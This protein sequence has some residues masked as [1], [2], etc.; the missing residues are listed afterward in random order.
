MRQYTEFT[1]KYLVALVTSLTTI[2]MSVA[3]E[4]HDGT[5][6]SAFGTVTIDGV[7][8][9]GEWDG[10]ACVAFNFVTFGDTHPTTF[11][12]K[13]DEIY[14]Y[15]LAV[16]QNEDFNQSLGSQQDVLRIFFDNNHNGGI[17]FSNSEAG[18]DFT[19]AP[20]PFVGGFMDG[21]NCQSPCPFPSGIQD[22]TELGGTN[23]VL[24]MITHTDPRPGSVGTYTFEFAKKLNSGDTPRD[25][26]LGAGDT[27]GVFLS[28]VDTPVGAA[29]GGESTWPG[30]DACSG[31]T[32]NGVPCVG[33]DI[34]IAEVPFL[35]AAI[36]I[37][38]GS[39]LNSINLS[40]A[41]VIPIAILSSPT[42]D[43]TQ[44][45]PASVR[46]AGAHVSLIGKADKYACHVEDVNREG[47]LDLIC[48][49]VTAQFA[50]QPGDS[51]A[52]ME[53][54]TF[55]GTRIRGEDAIRI[56]PD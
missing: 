42:F 2:G 35:R 46:L 17:A 55:N 37:K 29:A 40:A 31:F 24:A 9:T 13:N 10:S 5:A 44:I 54:E 14:L 22:D 18:D 7:A 8:S 32:S 36:D 41:G 15:L 21:F 45:N 53:A 51:V 47:L 39:N 34:V 43:A 27:V 3:A 16:I 20:K 11:C 50:I 33:A 4:A 38:P 52:V 56:V 48:Q 12:V 23:D 49:V 30:P 6:L 1:M 26:S 28:F 25:F 19:Q